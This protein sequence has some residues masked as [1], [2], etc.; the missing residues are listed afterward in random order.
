VRKPMPF[1]I[2]RITMLI[3]FVALGLGI[4]GSYKVTEDAFHTG[5]NV[6]NGYAESA[7][8]IFV[9]VFAGSILFFAYLVSQ[10]R[11]IP[12]Q[13][14]ITMSAVLLVIPLLTV[15]CVY[16]LISD[17]KHSGA[18]NIYSG[19]NTIYLCMDV[20]EEIL[21]V[22]ICVITGF[23]LPPWS[24]RESLD[25]EDLDAPAPKK[26]NQKHSRSPRSDS[27]PLAMAPGKQSSRGSQELRSRAKSAKGPI[28]W[29]YYSIADMGKK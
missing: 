20:I 24:K 11:D 21:V 7:L 2:Y 15:R 9:V 10:I 1:M 4:Y 19:N 17:F 8:I 18:F 14:R 22:W 26:R 29:I 25:Q 6:A 13:E 12:G 5:R 16:A 3:T 23:I 27:I 28:T